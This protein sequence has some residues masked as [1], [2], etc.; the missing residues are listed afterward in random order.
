MWRSQWTGGMLKLINPCSSASSSTVCTQ[1]VWWLLM[2][3]RDLSGA[4]GQSSGTWMLR[5]VSARGRAVATHHSHTGPRQLSPGASSCGAAGL[6]GWWGRRTAVP[7][8]VMPYLMADS[9]GLPGGAVCSCHV[10]VRRKAQ[11]LSWHPQPCHQV[12]LRLPGA[13]RLFVPS[14]NLLRVLYPALQALRCLP[15][16]AAWWDGKAHL[17]FCLLAK[18]CREI[19]SFWESV[20]NFWG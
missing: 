6:V 20:L 9:S 14:C 5:H 16:K 2:C 11:S 15:G 1:L 10:R 19:S 8:V 3:E 18:S 13:T 12:P 4:P 17:S 7:K